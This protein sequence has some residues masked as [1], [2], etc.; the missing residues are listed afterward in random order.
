MGDSVILMED[1]VRYYRPERETIDQTKKDKRI[2]TKNEG[3]LVIV[4]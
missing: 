1:F 3:W 4:N 2:E